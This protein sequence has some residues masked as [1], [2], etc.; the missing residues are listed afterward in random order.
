MNIIQELRKLSNGLQRRTA[1]VPLSWPGIG[2]VGHL[3]QEHGV[4]I[5]SAYRNAV[6]SMLRDNDRIEALAADVSSGR[7]A[8]AE[9]LEASRRISDTADP[10]QAIKRMQGAILSFNDV[11]DAR[12][13]GQ[14]YDHFGCKA[15]QTT[16]A[17]NWSAFNLVGGNPSAASYTA[18]PGGARMTSASTGAVPIPISIGGSDDAY[19]TNAVAN[20]VT[21]NN[22]H[23]FVDIL[24][25][26][27]TISATSATS[28]TINTTSLSRWTS[29]EGVYMTLEVTTQLG[30][31]AA[32]IN[33]STYTDQG[34][35]GSNAT[36]NIALTTSAIV[37]RLVPVQ[38]GP[39]IRLASGDYGVRSVEGLI[40]SA[41][42]GAGA[43]A[44]HLYKPLIV[45]PTMTVAFWVERSTPAQLSGIKKLTSVAGGEE[46]FIGR[47]VLPS[48]TSTGIILE[49]LEFVYS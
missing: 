15:S 40:L 6:D 2:P 34:G 4:Y 5:N 49:W 10:V 33:I 45:C 17:N 37:G 38:D 32:N 25:T 26:A 1:P 16:V 8:A 46:P 36:G 48:T 20:H 44:L 31:T 19:L 24:V 7:M 13:N 12:G 21:G 29:G 27:G 28:Q 35:T 11:I 3:T 14:Y 41:N 39:M 43:L 18:I 30:V 22:L 9:I 42:M 47:F 23:M